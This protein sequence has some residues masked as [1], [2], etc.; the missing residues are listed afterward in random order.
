[1]SRYD[2]S[3]V[4]RKLDAPAKFLLWDFD[5]VAAAAAGF[6]IGIIVN[7]LMIGALAS[8]VCMWAYVRLKAGR[9]PRYGLHCLYW[10][11]P[12]KTFKRTPPS[13]RRRFIG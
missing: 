10:H 5:Q 11:T 1:M 3:F 13:N 12:F 4:P 7:S 2:P 8:V 6:G 9:H